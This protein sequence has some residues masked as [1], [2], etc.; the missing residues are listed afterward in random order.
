MQQD[1]DAVITLDS[2]LK[3]SAFNFIIKNLLHALL[4]VGVGHLQTV[5]I[6]FFE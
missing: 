2:G 4:F 3:S 5:A 1:P 6:T